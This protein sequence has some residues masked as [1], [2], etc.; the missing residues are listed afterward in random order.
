MDR[1][2]DLLPEHIRGA[3]KRYIED[4]LQPGGFLE[5]VLSNDLAGAFGRADH[6]NR[7][8]LFDIV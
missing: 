5:A 4:R 7:D 8:R 1:N 6:I 3:M 2:Y